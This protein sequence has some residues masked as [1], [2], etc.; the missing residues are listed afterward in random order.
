[1]KIIKFAFLGRIRKMWFVNVHINNTIL[2]VFLAHFKCFRPKVYKCALNSRNF[3]KKLVEFGLWK[4][5]E[6]NLNWTWNEFES[7]NFDQMSNFHQ[8]SKCLL[9]NIKWIS[10][11]STYLPLDNIDTYVNR[12]SSNQIFFFTQKMFNYLL[13]NINNSVT[14]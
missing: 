7:H 14:L 6:T 10:M 8:M 12:F 5:C 3:L 2:C 1:M 13:C 11:I 4:L 9:M